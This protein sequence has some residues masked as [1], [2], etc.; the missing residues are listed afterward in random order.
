MPENLSAEELEQLCRWSTCTVSNAIELFDIRPRNE[1]IMSPKI[2]CL[3][4]EL[5][6]MI[7][8]AVTAKISAASPGDHQIS[9]EK[10]WEEILKMPAPRVLVIHDIDS[11]AIGSFWGEVRANIHRALG[12]IAAVT[13]GAVRDLD[14]VKD[15]RF[16]FFSTCV[17]VTHA[18]VHI[19]DIG[20]PVEV[21]GLI[22]RPGDLIM[23]DKHGI[24]S[25]PLQIARD[26]PEAAKLVEAWEQVVIEHCKSK[27]F[28]LEGLKERTG[29]AMPVWPPH[30]E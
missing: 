15:L 11:P 3:F 30:D 10:W 5:K 23:G 22:V 27:N 7:G 1:G 26:V 14:E 29:S 2:K 21:G 12:C 20:I 25:V 18:Y 28:S 19:I 16:H 8:Y 24:I 17:S 6:P 13:D 4:P 9:M